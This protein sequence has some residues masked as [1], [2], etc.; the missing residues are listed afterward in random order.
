MANEGKR[1]MTCHATSTSMCCATS[2]KLTP[3]D[4]VSCHAG[5]YMS[6]HISKGVVDHI[7]SRLNEFITRMFQLEIIDGHWSRKWV[8]G[9]MSNE[10]VRF[11][12]SPMKIID[13]WWSN[14][15]IYICV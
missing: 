9:Q 11:F 12:H 7:W 8:D 15:L 5:I 2:S 6:Y 10:L 13:D 14:R 4:Y 1:I 3:K